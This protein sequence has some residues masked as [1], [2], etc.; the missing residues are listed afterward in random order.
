MPKGDGNLFAGLEMA[1]KDFARG[2]V[3][4][5]IANDFID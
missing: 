3:A 4:F 2:S 5:E 1:S